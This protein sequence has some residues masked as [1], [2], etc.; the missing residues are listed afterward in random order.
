MPP[1]FKLVT[2]NCRTLFGSTQSTAEQLKRVRATHATLGRLIRS[3]DITLLQEAHG[4][5][6]DLSSSRHKF[7]E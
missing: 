6:A 7:P 4:S 2:W 3:A 5:E 1:K